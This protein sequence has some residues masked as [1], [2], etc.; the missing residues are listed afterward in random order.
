[1]ADN[2]DGNPVQ[3][4]IPITVIGG[5]D[6]TNYQAI[7]TTNDGTV[8]TS[9]AAVTQVMSTALESSHVLKALAGQLVQ[10]SVFSSK[11]S[12]QY[13]LILNS[14]TVSVDGAVTLLYPP[15]PI[16]AGTLLVLDFPVPIEASAGI[17]VCNSSTGTFTKTI[18]SADCVFYAQVN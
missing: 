17:T 14:A 16:A 4:P 18:G 10:L 9:A 2:Y 13:I 7:K 5:S 11:V 1:M 15:I 8:V 6:G 3:T 12:A